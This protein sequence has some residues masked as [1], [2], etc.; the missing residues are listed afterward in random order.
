MQSEKATQKDAA[1]QWGKLED[2]AA[3]ALTKYGKLA[4]AVKAL[5]KAL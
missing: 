5:D 1:K 2:E 3:T 4:N